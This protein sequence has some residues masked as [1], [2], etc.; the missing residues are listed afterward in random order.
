MSKLTN[1]LQ[2]KTLKFILLNQF[3][4]IDVEQ[5]KNYAHVIT[6]YKIIE[7]NSRREEKRERENAI[8]GNK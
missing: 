4:Q 6:K 5:L 8:C 2:A 3:V 1:E 7:P